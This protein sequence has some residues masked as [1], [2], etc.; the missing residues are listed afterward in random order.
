MSFLKKLFFLEADVLVKTAR[1][2]LVTESD[3]LQLPP[4]LNPRYDLFD[5][6]KLNFESPKKHLL[7]TLVAGKKEMLP[8]FCWYLISTGLALLTPYLVNRFIK[9]IENGVNDQNIVELLVT[10]FFL[11]ISGFMT[12]FILQHYFYR[13]LRSYQ[14]IV[15]ILNRRIFT[16]SLKLTLGARQKNMLG[17]IVNFMGTDS[18]SV[19]DSGTAPGSAGGI[20]LP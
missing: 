18:E 4:E 20:A 6:K 17:D 19:A 14:V 15:N 13:E 8:A 9:I 12:G 7:S 1:E 11:G 10:G 2:R 16:H 5:E 3:M